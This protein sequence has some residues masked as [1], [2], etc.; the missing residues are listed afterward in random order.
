MKTISSV[1]QRFTAR[2]LDFVERYFFLL[3]I[4]GLVGALMAVLYPITSIPGLIRAYGAL[5][6]IWGV[7][8][9]LLISH[10]LCRQVC[11][12][13]RADSGYTQA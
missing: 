6:S 7:G 12:R 4:T 3:V 13:A 9:Y 2:A 11:E 1:T 10:E 5:L 8:A